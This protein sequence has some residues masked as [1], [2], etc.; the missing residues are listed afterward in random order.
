MLMYVHTRESV[1][2]LSRA[3]RNL[4]P[5]ALGQTGVVASSCQTLTWAARG[6][7]SVVP[8]PQQLWQAL[9]RRWFLPDGNCLCG[10]WMSS[11]SRPST[12]SHLIS[13][14]SVCGLKPEPTLGSQA[15]GQRL[16]RRVCL[17]GTG[18]ERNRSVQK[19]VLEFRR[20]FEYTGGV[21]DCRKW[22]LGSWWSAAWYH[23]SAHG[24]AAAAT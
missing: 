6:T 24:T 14:A 12:V 11:S 17:T 18:R 10:G 4:L 7:T 8:L 21:V 15:A 5:E 20:V 23:P 13:S 19:R 2:G 22:R 1:Q 16:M 9:A 3:L